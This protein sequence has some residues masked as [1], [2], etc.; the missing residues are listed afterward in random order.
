MQPIASLLREH[1]VD[2]AA[3]LRECGLPSTALDDANAQLSFRMGGCL[4][5]RAAWALQR[6]DFGLL[7][8]QRFELA[9]LGLL[10]DLVRQAPTLGAALHSLVRFIHLQDRGSVLYLRRPDVGPVAIGYAIHDDEVPGS[11]LIYDA[12]MAMVLGTLRELCGAS[13]SAAELHLAHAAP[14]DTSPYRRLF[15]VPVVFDEPHSELLF[16]RYWLDAP[17]A[18]AGDDTLVA[19]R[20]AAQAAEA[21]D[22]PHL[23][24]RVRVAVRV[25][26]ATGDVSAPR[27][28]EAL[29][30]HER[31]LRRHLAQTGARLQHI[32][33][34]ERCHVAKQ[35]L[36]ETELA[37]Q[38]IGWALGY[39]DDTSFVRAF[40]GWCGCTP[41]Q[42]RAAA[43]EV[44]KV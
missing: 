17:V 41:G 16:D 13:F 42:W 20:R 35:L 5:Q 31:T 34:D 19:L 25:L 9:S 3:V 7:V 30:L 26:L 14:A 37:V 32:V 27:L 18:G 44:A 12:V 2:V 40:R 39:A 28:A 29:G 10:G 23:D 15:G 43:R 8:G 22:P 33:A 24:E 1:G 11:A 21:V 4:F 6:A 36:R 38:D